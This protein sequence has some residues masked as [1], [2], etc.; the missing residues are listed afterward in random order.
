MNCEHINFMTRRSALK[1]SLWVIGALALIVI[2]V[3]YLTATKYEVLVQVISENRVGVN[4]TEEKLDFGDLPHDKS[5]I[6][7]VTLNSRGGIDS[8]IIVYI[9]GDIA[10]LLKV[11]KNYFTL[12]AGASE[13]LEFSL[14]IPPSAAYRYYRGRVLIFQL[15]KFW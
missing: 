14:Y 5:A 1:I 7:S 3:Q 8:Y 15:P 6:R 9:S 12:P 4:P 13:K 11:N 10:D 2:V